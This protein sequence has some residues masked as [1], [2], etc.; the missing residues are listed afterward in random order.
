M[1][2]TIYMRSEAEIMGMFDKFDAEVSKDDVDIDTEAVWEALRY[3][4]FTDVS[5]NDIESYL[6]LN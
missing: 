4:L 2:R 1:R 6:P 3:V 5:A